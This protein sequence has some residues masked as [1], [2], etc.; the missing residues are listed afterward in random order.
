MSVCCF[1]NRSALAQRLETNIK[2]AICLDPAIWPVQLPCDRHFMCFQ[3]IEEFVV[4][5]IRNSGCMR[6]L[7]D[8]DLECRSIKNCVLCV[9]TVGHYNHTM[10]NANPPS[11]LGRMLFESFDPECNGATNKGI[12]PY[13]QV[14]DVEFDHVKTCP[15]RQIECTMCSNNFPC[16]QPLLAHVDHCKVHNCP[17]CQTMGLSLREVNHHK[18]RHDNYTRRMTMFLDSV[19]EM[20]QLVVDDLGFR[21]WPDLVRLHDDVRSLISTARALPIWSPS[22]FPDLRPVLARG[23]VEPY[24]RDQH[25]V[26]AEHPLSPQLDDGG[27]ANFRDD[28]S[29]GHMAAYA[30]LLEHKSESSVVIEQIVIPDEDEVVEHQDVQPRN[31]TRHIHDHLLPPTIRPGSTVF[32]DEHTWRQVGRLG[33]FNLQMKRVYMRRINELRCMLDVSAL[34]DITKQNIRNLITNDFQYMNQW[35]IY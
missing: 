2:C 35:I 19:D 16:S 3:C 34:E 11:A 9:T 5:E 13:C 25:F 10:S 29:V 1:L 23:Q 33:R 32:L 14:V 7:E 22:L 28:L 24:N 31:G 4:R 27:Y 26:D 8:Y 30:D 18:T 15:R 21:L 17:V 12:C 20:R 6:S